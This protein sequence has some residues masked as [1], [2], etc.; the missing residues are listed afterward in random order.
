MK[1]IIALLAACLMIMTMIT[2]FTMAAEEDVVGTW[3]AQSME[4]DGQK[5]DASILA[6]LG[7]DIVITLDEDGTATMKMAGQEMTGT[8]SDGTIVFNDS[9]TQFE[10]VDGQM[11]MGM[12]GAELILGKEPPEAMD[13]NLAPAVENPEL[14]DFNGTWNAAAYVTMGM[15]LPLNMMGTELSLDIKD[16]KAAY[17]EKTFDLNNPEDTNEI[18]KEFSAKLD[19]DGTL[20]VDFDGEEVLSLVAPGSSGIRLT[21]HEDGRISGEIPEVTEAMK[22]FAESSSGDEN[23]NAEGA[24]GTEGDSSSSSGE[25]ML[26]V[27]IIFLKAE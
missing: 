24:E 14:S 13:V 26:D 8:W 12:N 15:P 9:P 2:G 25:S 17:K 22:M 20:F 4:Q 19:D 16:G 1:K 11:K 23:E 7:M 10:L 21:L 6:S 3:Y 27:Y 5:V 18:E